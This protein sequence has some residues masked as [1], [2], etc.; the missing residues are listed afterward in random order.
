MVS[1][2]LSVRNESQ[3][4]IACLSNLACLEKYQAQEIEILIGDDASQD[5]TVSLI[6]NFI[7]GKSNFRL[8]L[9]T[10]KVA[11]LQGKANVL[12]QLAQKA[13]GEWLFFTDAD[14]QFSPTW[15][16]TMLEEAKKKAANE[17]NLALQMGFTTV[18]PNS[19]FAKLQALDWT[20]YLGIIHIFSIF[21]VP[22]T[23]MG[24]N[25]AIK[26][27]AYQKIGGYENISFS[28]TEDYAIFQAL[29]KQGYTFSHTANT[30]VLGYTQ[31][32]DSL[33]NLLQQRRRWLGEFK[34]FAWWIQGSIFFIGFY[35]PLLLLFLTVPN[36]A[37]SFFLFRFVMLYSIL[38]TYC[39]K[40]KQYTVLPYLFF[41]DIFSLFF[42][43]LVILYLVGSNKIYWKNREYQA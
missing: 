30:E 9:I 19:F 20:F 41:Y 14:M 13:K 23:A 3:N 37:L 11:N 7:V 8:F 15:V 26:K 5:D 31:A 22:I 4:I 21:N 40:T 42:Y 34:N 35:L 6:Q 29:M 38:T 10:K 17:P 28:V 18:V 27:E 12:A 32:A 36:I 25:M 33:S 1:I 39:L 43:M 16:Q 2:L 24:N